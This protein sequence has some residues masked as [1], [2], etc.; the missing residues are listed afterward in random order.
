MKWLGITLDIADPDYQLTVIRILGQGNGNQVELT[1]LADISLLELFLE[2][3]S[4]QKYDRVVFY[5]LHELESWS[6][7]KVLTD[8]CARYGMS[9]SFL[10][11]DLHSDEKIEFADL[12]AVI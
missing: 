9:F 4:D 8:V 3:K 1:Q 7:L 10:R 2:M 5:D 12:I 6:N 11:Q